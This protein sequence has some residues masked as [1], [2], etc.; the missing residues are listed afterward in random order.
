MLM[1][2]NNGK[3]I[4][5]PNWNLVL[6]LSA[7]SI[8]LTWST[9]HKVGLYQLSCMFLFMV[10]CYII[11]QRITQARGNKSVPYGMLFTKLFKHKKIDLSKEVVSECHEKSI[12]GK[13]FVKRLLAERRRMKEKLA[14]EREKQSWLNHLP[15][16]VKQSQRLATNQRSDENQ[17][18]ARSRIRPDS[19][20][21]DDDLDFHVRTG[22]NL[23]LM[24]KMTKRGH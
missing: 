12:L 20:P 10:F 22:E 23:W 16:T 11:T 6:D 8:N 1:I 9:L 15:L 13:H 14:R 18:S 2:V 7:N 21:N 19:S 5:S 24:R 3:G 4:S 17:E